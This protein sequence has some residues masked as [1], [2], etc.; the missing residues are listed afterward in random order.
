MISAVLAPLAP[1]TNHL[2]QSTLF[3]AVVGL[4]TLA[5]RR[6]RAHVRYWLWLA[7]SYKFLLPFSCLVS[8]G[9]LFQW[10][11]ASEIMSPALLT[12][13]DAIGGPIFLTAFPTS[14]TTSD[15]P[16]TLFVLIWA[17]WA[18]GFVTVAVGWVREWMRIDRIVR[19]ASPLPLGLPI[20]AMSAPARLEPG[21][22]GVFRPV[23]LLPEG[24]TS[25]LTQAQLQAVFAHELCHVRR[26]DNL[27]AGV[28]MLVEALFWFHPLVWW[29]G[30]RLIDEREHACDEEV[31]ETGIQAKTYAESILKVCEFYLESPSTCLSGVTGSDLKKRIRRV[32]RS[33]FGEVLGTSKRLL[34]MTAGI[35]ALAMPI[36]AGVLIFPGPRLNQIFGAKAEKMSFEVASVKLNKTEGL[37]PTSNVSLEVDDTFAP[38]GGLLSATNTPLFVLLRFAYKSTL[39]TLDCQ[40]GAGPIALTSRPERRAI[41]PRTSFAS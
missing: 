33:Q 1:V 36:V 18:G 7:A 13:T 6:N 10:H 31:L 15:H 40:L 34:L 2:W 30:G 9:R 25:R 32:I 14:K 17:V 38:T 19:A 8:V 35:V 26:R 39:S 29:L 24:I 3:A 4:I 16:P 12:V 20:P 5:L 22:F 37:R 21:V 27:A 28:H 11:A 23:L 41:P